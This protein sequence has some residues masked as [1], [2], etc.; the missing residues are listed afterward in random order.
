[1]YLYCGIYCVLFTGKMQNSLRMRRLRDVVH[2][3]KREV[4]APIECIL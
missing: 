1:M 4:V 3:Y 2:V